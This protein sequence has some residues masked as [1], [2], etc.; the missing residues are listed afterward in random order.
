MVTDRRIHHEEVM[1]KLADKEAALKVQ[2]E[3]F[4]RE[5]ALKDK[6]AA[7]LAAEAAARETAWVEEKNIL[8][9]D[10]AA[11]FRLQ[12]EGL[13]KRESVLENQ[14]R[15]KAA[16]L[17]KNAAEVRDLMEAD[18]QRRVE[19]EKQGFEDAKARLSDENMLKGEQLAEARALASE[20]VEKIKAAYESKKADL[21]KQYEVKLASASTALAFEKARMVADLKTASN[22]YTRLAE[23][24]KELERTIASD[25][26]AHHEE[27][28]KNLSEKEGALKAQTDDFNRQALKL[29][30]NLSAKET[31]W[32]AEREE[33]RAAS[34]GAVARAGREAA[35][36]AAR[37][38]GEYEAKKTELQRILNERLV[39]KEAL[40]KLET[41]KILEESRLKDER[42]AATHSRVKEL[43]NKMNAMSC[44]HHEELAARLAEKEAALKAQADELNRD[45][46]EA[47]KAQAG[48]FVGELAQAREEFAA[49]EADWKREKEKQNALA[50]ETVL[51]AEREIRERAAVLC[52]EY[53]EK[54]A[55]LERQYG[56]KSASASEALAF[57]KA[58]MIADMKTASAEYT[59]LTEKFRELENTIASDRQRHH[60]ELM[61]KLADKEAALKA[62]AAGFSAEMANLHDALIVREA[63]WSSEREKLAAVSAEAEARAER[64][65]KDR[66]VRMAGEY[67]VKKAELE[68]ILSERLA[69]KEAVLNLEAKKILEESRLKDERLA[70]THLR[71]KE[72]ENK[73][74]A[75]SSAHHE[76]LAARLAE[77]EAALKAQADN[78]NKERDSMLAAQN[79]GSAKELAALRANFSAK[80]AAW[81]SEKEKMD[82]ALA[83]ISARAEREVKAQAVSMGA[84]Y[85]GKKTELEK[86][87]SEKYAAAE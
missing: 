50:A 48:G 18:F 51:N 85:E 78:F 4:G 10:F 2:A 60:A 52:A 41:G 21:E 15:L 23:Q 59:K 30:E 72:L 57:E 67:E 25:R 79:S 34:E 38:A 82:S 69:E 70:A 55:E 31:A 17:E 87:F 73:A 74:D 45:K 26:Q 58:G 20:R 6:R 43:E 44:A 80:E 19:V 27:L 81:K 66:S 68:R 39:E 71:V 75:V 3:K 65:I 12:E 61:E 46:G 32:L 42:L 1:E 56:E 86:Y 28:M 24:V 77:K 8:S 83:E 40:L 14:Y 53:E 22:E 54:K 29:R 33:L 9:G 62:Q 37:M 63:G 36:R 64:E 13:A 49:R 16:E 47:L 7:Q 84:D 76:E 35:G 5:L 11:R